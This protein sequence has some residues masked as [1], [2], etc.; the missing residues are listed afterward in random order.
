M[1]DGQIAMD[2]ALLIKSLFL[3]KVV[4]EVIDPVVGSFQLGCIKGQIRTIEATDIC[5]MNLLLVIHSFIG[6]LQTGNIGR[7]PL[8]E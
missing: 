7:Q 4:P 3:L 2:S 5:M 6:R 8:R 1:G